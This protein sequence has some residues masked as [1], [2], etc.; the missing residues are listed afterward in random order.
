MPTTTLL[1]LLSNTKEEI[2]QKLGGGNRSH[3]RVGKTRGFPRLSRQRWITT[4]FQLDEVR[5]MMVNQSTN[6][7]HHLVQTTMWHRT[8]QCHHHHHHHQGKGFRGRQDH[9]NRV[10][11]LC[12]PPHRHH[13]HR[14]RH[15]QRRQYQFQVCREQ[16][17]R[18]TT[19]LQDTTHHRIRY[20]I[21]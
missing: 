9:E 7:D 3:L 10:T 20:W 5:I 11:A 12:K 16:P 19:N 1:L 21:T 2:M 18:L 14:P 15:H 13:H 4:T 17:A 8:T 6:D